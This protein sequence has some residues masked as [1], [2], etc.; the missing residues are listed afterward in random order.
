MKANSKL[1]IQ[2]K[3][4]SRAGA[5]M[6]SAI[7][8]TSFAGL[9]QRFDVDSATQFGKGELVGAVVYSD[10]SVAPGIKPK[11]ITLKDT[12]LAYSMV[13][14]AKGVTY[15]GT[16]REGKIYKLVNEHV[17]LLADTNELMVA[18]LALDL[19][20]NLYAGTSPKGIVYKVDPKG[21]LT[22][23]STIKDAEHVWSLYYD[24]NKKTLFAGTGPNGKIYSINA[25]GKAALYYRTDGLHVMCLARDFDGN[26]LAGTSQQ[27]LLYRVR[28][29]QKAEI[30]FSFP[31]DEV[32]RMDVYKDI[33]A[34]ASNSFGGGS[35]NT[36]GS[37]TSTASRFDFLKPS[38]AGDGQNGIGELWRIGKDNK[39]E[40]IYRTTQ[41]YLTSLQI[42][43]DGAIYA[44]TGQGGR[45]VRVEP[46]LRNAIWADV[47]ERQVLA[48]DIRG[49]HP[50]FVTGDPGQ[51]YTMNPTTAKT[52]T[53]LS[54][55][56]DAQFMARWGRL[57]WRAR[58]GVTFQTRT[59][60]T[61]KPNETW[62][63]WSS[64]MKSPGMMTSPS[65]RYVQVRAIFGG[66]PKAKLFAMSLYYLPVNQRAH[67]TD[68]RVAP[69]MVPK[70]IAVG[71][72]RGEILQ[73][74][75]L[76][77]RWDADN[78]DNDP[79]R[80][81]IKFKAEQ[82]EVWRDIVPETQ[83]LSDNEYT[84]DTSG[85]PDG[86]YVVEVEG[87]DELTNPK[88]LVLKGSELSEPIRVDNHAPQ[89]SKLKWLNGVVTG[90]IS[91]SIGPIAVLEFAVDGTGWH[92][93]APDDGLLDSANE[94]I[95]LR[96]SLAS[97]FTPG[98]PHIIA[99]R[100]TDAAGNSAI[101]EI[102]SH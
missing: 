20:G 30:I 43:D 13:R 8:S 69:A 76:K 24:P 79:L 46:D 90:T 21:K 34:V 19:Q 1:S 22:T 6:L 52:P 2:M 65:A 37:S 88:D 10:G 15:I 102:T 92:V 31:G 59:G 45:I 80:Y 49:G 27:A 57:T 16:G 63:G 71:G 55:I 44:G 42:G 28:S 94:R 70:P 73:N 93:F 66:D 12:S 7:A 3:W 98:K 75:K 18:S 100:A 95:A 36:F 4:S 99:V 82:Q 17:S 67:V 41:S 56:F 14:D 60:N 33:I 84:W 96:P 64:V 5:L 74:T 54:D 85:I 97:E 50:V 68:V 83:V 48:L 101:A 40:R 72:M 9:T 39:P 91:D 78:P 11:K 47:D 23:F 61:P 51:I 26:L 29:P 38:Q 62:S 86:Y 87:S 25:Q 58:G 89:I 81:R 77:L 53:W 35:R 32:T